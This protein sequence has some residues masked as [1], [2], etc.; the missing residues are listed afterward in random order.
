MK[1]LVAGCL[2]FLVFAVLVAYSNASMEKTQVWVDE[3]L[4][5]TYSF[6]GINSTV[7][8]EIKQQSVFNQTSIPQTILSNLEQQQLTHVA[9]YTAEL[10]FNDSS[11]SVR[12]AFYMSGSDVLSL[13]I[14]QTTA[15]KI[16][17]MKTSWI[18]FQVK[19]TPTLL[20]NFTQYF[21]KPVDQ[22]QKINYTDTEKRTHPAYYFDYTGQAPFHH[23]CYFIL[24]TE[25]TN[26]Q[27]LGDTI[28]FELPPSTGDVLLNS[29]FTILGTLIIVIIALVLYRR[30]RK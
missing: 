30:V 10:S 2:L 17:T 12:V 22:W 26:V 16:Y 21:G 20:L 14:N 11:N 13:T 23:Q 18:N 1:H 25:A 24:P 27:A 8:Q 6:E 15:T 5:V 28:T 7:Y 4:Y 3:S 29:P 19:L 9:F